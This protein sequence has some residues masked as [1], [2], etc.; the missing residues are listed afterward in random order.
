VGGLGNLNPKSVSFFLCTLS[1]SQAL[2]SVA[3]LRP[4]VL[5]VDL[6]GCHRPLNRAIQFGMQDHVPGLTSSRKSWA[7][8]Q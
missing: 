4:L 3:A 6:L 2:P 7:N 1:V 5:D 8:V